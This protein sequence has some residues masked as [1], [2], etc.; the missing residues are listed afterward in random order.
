MLLSSLRVE[1]RN[2]YPPH[3]NFQRERKGMRKYSPFINHSVIHCS[4]VPKVPILPPTLEFLRVEDPNHFLA[5]RNL[6]AL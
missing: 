6:R 3:P 2:Q 5:H 1:T 4:P